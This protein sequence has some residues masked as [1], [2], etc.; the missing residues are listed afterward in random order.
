MAKPSK[1]RSQITA[2]KLLLLLSNFFSR[3]SLFGAVRH[4]DNNLIVFVLVKPLD[5]PA[6]RGAR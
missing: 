3:H 1:E 5:R 2:P 6:W 4:G